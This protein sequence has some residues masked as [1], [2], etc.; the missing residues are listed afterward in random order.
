VSGGCRPGDNQ[1]KTAIRSD[2]VDKARRLSLPVAGV[3]FQLTDYSIQKAIGTTV[4][5]VM[6]IANNPVPFQETRE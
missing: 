4:A 1:D 2:I 6:A 5:E 3:F